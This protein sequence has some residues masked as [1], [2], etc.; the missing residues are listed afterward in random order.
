MQAQVPVVTSTTPCLEAERR[1]HAQHTN[2]STYTAERVSGRCILKE[3]RDAV[4]ETISTPH[5][6]LQQL[7]W[8]ASLATLQATR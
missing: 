6:G 3:Q 5:V 8:H 7:C 1:V 2:D 4:V